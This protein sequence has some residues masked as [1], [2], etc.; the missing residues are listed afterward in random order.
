M[1][2]CIVTHILSVW[3]VHSIFPYENGK[4]E[5]KEFSKKV[6]WGL[7][8]VADFWYQVKITCPLTWMI[9]M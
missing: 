3:F 1:M 9:W 5:C 6:C 7:K 8:T 4:E 2:L